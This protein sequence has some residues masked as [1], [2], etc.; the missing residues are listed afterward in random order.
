M[1]DIQQNLSYIN[2]ILYLQVSFLLTP[3][4]KSRTVILLLL[5][6][7][8]FRILNISCIF[9]SHEA[10]MRYLAGCGS[11]LSITLCLSAIGLAGCYVFSVW[12]RGSKKFPPGLIFCSFSRFLVSLAVAICLFHCHKYS[13]IK[14]SPLLTWII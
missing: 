14:S 6:C 9:P 2:Y 8:S 11:L 12:Q 13:M 3:K 5:S 1:S 10:A 4:K 7:S